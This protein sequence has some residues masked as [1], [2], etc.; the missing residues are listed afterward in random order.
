M[1]GRDSVER[2]LAVEDHVRGIPPVVPLGEAGVVGLETRHDPRQAAGA[3]EG[4][5]AAELG[6]GVV[7]VLRVS[8]RL[9]GAP[10]GPEFNARLANRRQM[11]WR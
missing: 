10:E 11:P 6:G 7:E 1:A 3:Q 5:Q 8:F 2:R 4:G 9:L